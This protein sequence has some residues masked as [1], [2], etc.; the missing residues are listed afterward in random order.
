MKKI[1]KNQNIENTN[2]ILPYLS[3]LDHIS[4]FYQNRHADFGIKIARMHN[5]FFISSS[6]LSTDNS[7]NEYPKVHYESNKLNS[8]FS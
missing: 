7:K 6:K 1:K 5:I 8:F 2:V 3:D 4:V